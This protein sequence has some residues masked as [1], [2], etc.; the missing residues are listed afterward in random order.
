MVEKLTQYVMTQKEE[1]VKPFKHNYIGNTYIFFKNGFE[2]DN[3]EFDRKEY[4][5]EVASIDIMIESIIKNCVD[6]GKH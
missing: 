3:V 2:V 6:K 4:R 1:V 5:V